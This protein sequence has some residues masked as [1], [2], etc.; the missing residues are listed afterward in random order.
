MEVYGASQVMPYQNQDNAQKTQHY[1]ES[2][3]AFAEY[4][5]KTPLEHWREKIIEEMG[6]TEEAIAALPPE[7]RALVE[8][9]IQ[10]KME[11]IM[12]QQAFLEE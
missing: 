4:M 11:Q 2:T 7:K 10:R 3:K 12:Q 5:E 9:K 6:L 1:S 8:D